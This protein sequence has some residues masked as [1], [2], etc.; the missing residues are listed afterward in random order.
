MMSAFPVSL[1]ERLLA[2][3]AQLQLRVEDVDEQFVRGSGPGG[4]KINKTACC[5]HLVHLPTGVEVRGQEFREQ[6]RNRRWAW[7]NLI[8]KLEEK[9]KGADSD[10]MKKVFKLRKQK[11]KRS[12]RAKEKV[13]EAKR[14]RGEIKEMRRDII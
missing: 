2:K 13:L 1:P 6:S 4:Q 10:R 14:R 7:Q 5:V 8:L 12:K 3:A 9:I 11:A